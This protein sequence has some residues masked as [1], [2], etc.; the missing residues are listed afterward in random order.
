MADELSVSVDEAE[1]S[2]RTK[3]LIM[4]TAVGAGLGLLGSFMLLT[5]MKKNK[6]EISVSAAD[7]IRLGL[8]LAA[9]L[10]NIYELPAK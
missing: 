4:G 6:G 8:I 1:A 7:G 10:R 5:S 2:T 9:L 3:V